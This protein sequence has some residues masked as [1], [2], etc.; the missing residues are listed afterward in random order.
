MI[1]VNG[2]FEEIRMSAVLVKGLKVL[3]SPEKRHDILMDK[4]YLKALLIG[5]VGLTAIKS[6]EVIEKGILDFMKREN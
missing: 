1:E 4:S 5:M 6:N 2:I 3:N